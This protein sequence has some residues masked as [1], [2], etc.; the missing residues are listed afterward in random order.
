MHVYMKAIRGT[1]VP[2]L[3]T[4]SASSSCLKK[5]VNQF[6]PSCEE[7]GF[8]V[9]LLRKCHIPFPLGR[10]LRFSTPMRGTAQLCLRWRMLVLIETH[11][12][13]WMLSLLLSVRQCRMVTSRYLFAVNFIVCHSFSSLMQYGPGTLKKVSIANSGWESSSWA[14]HVCLCEIPS[15]GNSSSYL[16]TAYWWTS[17]S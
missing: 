17:C 9:T 14:L 12:N 2:Q 4:H 11:L 15:D 8:D 3:K 13:I 6:N 5:D 1:I 16:S 7:A 10:F